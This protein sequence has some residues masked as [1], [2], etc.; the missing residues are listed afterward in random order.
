MAK[1]QHRGD[2][3]GVPPDGV[4]SPEPQTG[5]ERRLARR[6]GKLEPMQPGPPEKGPKGGRHRKG[7]TMPQDGCA[8]DDSGTG[9]P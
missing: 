7:R 5:R 8:N 6:L 9:P 2:G 3:D 4:R 1:G